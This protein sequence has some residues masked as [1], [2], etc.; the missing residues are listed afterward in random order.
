MIILIQYIHKYSRAR[1]ACYFHLTSTTNIISCAFNLRLPDRP[2]YRLV[3]ACD[4][5][6]L[7][8]DFL[9]QLVYLDHLALKV[10]VDQREIPVSPVPLVNQDDLDLTALQDPKVFC[11]YQCDVSNGTG[12]YQSHLTVH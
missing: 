4:R 3:C 11:N 2:K 10:S 5:V 8:L 7:A 9:V 6:N 1:L 12:S